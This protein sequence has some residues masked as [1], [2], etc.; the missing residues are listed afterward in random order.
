MCCNSSC[1]PLSAIKASCLIWE[2]SRLHIQDRGEVEQDQHAATWKEQIPLSEWNLPFYWANVAQAEWK[3]P[4]WEVF[5]KAEKCM[6]TCKFLSIQFN[7]VKSQLHLGRECFSRSCNLKQTTFE[8]QNQNSRE[9]LYVM[10][11]KLPLHM[12]Y[13]C[14]V[15]RDFTMPLTNYPS[16]SW[17]SVDL[18]AYTAIP[19][20]YLW[21][22]SALPVLCHSYKARLLAV[23]QPAS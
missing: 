7:L 15:F 6:T 8:K 3:L 1:C 22:I 21:Y 10:E 2:S 13:P 11:F 12:T 19:A 23:S 17:S 4:L 14:N 9:I 20:Q 5:F 18:A 16:Y